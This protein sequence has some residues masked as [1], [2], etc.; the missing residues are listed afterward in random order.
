MYT[1]FTYI[2]N[3]WGALG[4][5]LLN[6]EKVKKSIRSLLKERRHKRTTIKE[7]KVL[8]TLS[9]NDLISPLIS[10]EEDLCVNRDDKDKKKKSIAL[11]ASRIVNNE[12][13]K[14]KDEDMV[15]IGRKFRKFFKKFN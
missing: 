5:T 11:K 7:A 12:K 13:N 1:R 10:Y 14:F 6:S 2:V 9:T 3:T 15:V 4:N 8:N